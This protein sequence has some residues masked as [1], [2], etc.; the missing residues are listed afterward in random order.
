LDPNHPAPLAPLYMGEVSNAQ[1][2]LL[3]TYPLI[4]S[5]GHTHP[6]KLYQLLPTFG[7]LPEGLN[8]EAHPGTE[9]SGGRVVNRWD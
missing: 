7:K 1:V 6:I 9:P 4:D 2:I 5:E 3:N 8:L